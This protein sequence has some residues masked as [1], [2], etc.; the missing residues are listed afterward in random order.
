MTG[1]EI[2]A[3]IFQIVIIPLL[4]ILT[5]YLVALITTKIEEIKE[6]KDDITFNKYAD[7]VKETV[8][9]CVLATNQTYVDTLKE[10][11]KFDAEAQ[12]VAF[13]KTFEAVMNILSADAKKYLTN[14]IGDLDKY[15]T[16]AIE[17]QVTS[18]KTVVG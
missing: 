10:Q 7:F 14:A 18:V 8:T 3:I 16:D 15:V 1:A 2:I 17:A 6:V 11:G 5:K 9:N 12:K 4:G 13:Q